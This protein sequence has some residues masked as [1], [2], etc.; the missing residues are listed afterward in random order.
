MS[1][2]NALKGMFSNKNIITFFETFLFEL[3][4]IFMSGQLSDVL[5]IMSGELSGWAFVRIS[6]NCADLKW[7]RQM[8]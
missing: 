4:I 3:P 2:N 8:E 1:A 7:D 5:K 6:N